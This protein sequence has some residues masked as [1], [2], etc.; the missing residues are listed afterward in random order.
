MN[1]KQHNY[2]INILWT[3]NRGSGTSGYR[4]YDRSHVIQIENKVEIHSSS[5]PAFQG[6]NTK[7]NPE[8]LFLAS[9]SSCHMLWYLHL[10]ADAGI[11]ITTYKDTATAVMTED[12]VRG[13]YFVSATLNPV[14]QVLENSMIKKAN[15]LHEAAHKKCF[16]ANSVNFPVNHNP[17]CT[18]AD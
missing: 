4:S 18:K 9:L 13:G 3:G 16:I 11:I 15:D 8:E 5:D 1:P 2:S 10:C 17:T 7:H 12:T 14:V 6:D